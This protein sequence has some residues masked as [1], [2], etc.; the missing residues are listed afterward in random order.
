MTIRKTQCAGC[1][2]NF[3]N[4]NNNLSVKECWSFKGAKIVSRIPVGHWE[5]PPYLN[6]QKVQVPDC[7]HGEGSNR[8]HYISPEQIDSRGYWK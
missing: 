3:Y 5:N 4:G 2:N 8:T 6:K 7:Y 1:R